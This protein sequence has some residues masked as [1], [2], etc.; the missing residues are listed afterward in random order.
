MAYR[1]LTGLSEANSGGLP[2]TKPDDESYVYY[3]KM[4]VAYDMLHVATALYVQSN[5]V[6][7]VC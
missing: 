6:R 5:N 7:H 4:C 3:M 1:Q 2:K